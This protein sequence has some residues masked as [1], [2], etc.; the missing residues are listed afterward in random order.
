MLLE[1]WGIICSVFCG[2]LVEIKSNSML[3]GEQLNKQKN[4]FHFSRLPT[5][6]Q[7]H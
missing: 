4:F 5:K 2:P 1:E 7:T 6:A 3:R